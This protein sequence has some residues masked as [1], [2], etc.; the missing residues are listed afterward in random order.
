LIQRIRGNERLSP[1]IPEKTTR[2]DW[3]TG[4]C[5]LIRRAAIE[6]AGMMDEQFFLYWE[7]ADLCERLRAA[8]WRT[9]YLPS[10]VVTH[11]V[12]RSRR[13]AR[14]LSVRAFHRSAY[15]YFAKHRAGRFRAVS[16]P[17]AW[18]LLTARML[19]KLAVQVVTRRDW[20]D[21]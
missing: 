18:T 20:S 1:R 14:S 2:V 7:D 9:A 8:G 21:R 11:G 4:A 5:M 13:H 17:V 3:V 19:V 15:L 10:A 6:E 12:G 16:L